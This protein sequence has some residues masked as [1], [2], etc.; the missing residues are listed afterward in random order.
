MFGNKI[1][2]DVLGQLSY[3]YGIAQKFINLS[4]KYHWCLDLIQEPPHCPIDSTII[5]KTKYRGNL[6]YTNYKKT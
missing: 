4:L 5:N 3:K 6:N 1:G 2:S